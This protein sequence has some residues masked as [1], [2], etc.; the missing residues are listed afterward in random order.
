[1]K[2][3]VFRQQTVPR[4][5]F[6]DYFHSENFDAF[7]YDVVS[8]NYVT[9]LCVQKGATEN[10]VGEDVLEAQEG[11]FLVIPPLTRHRARTLIP[12]LGH[13]NSSAAFF[14]DDV[15]VLNDEQLQGFLKGCGGDERGMWAVLPLHF[16]MEGSYLS[17]KLDE[18][19]RGEKQKG[20][21]AGLH[22][23]GL[24][25]EICYLITEK[26]LRSRGTPPVPSQLMYCQKMC[27]YLELHYEKPLT[28]ETVFLVTGLNAEY[29]RRIFKKT[30]GQ[31]P[32]GYLLSVRMEEAKRLLANTADSVSEVARKVGYEDVNYFTRLFV[33]TEHKSP[34]QYRAML[35][36]E[37]VKYEETPS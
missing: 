8:L 37:W 33:R 11:D 25:M 31:S 10:T 6:A 19:I 2:Y 16:R 9:V 29:F 17:D 27:R 22:C 18:L 36:G 23:A 21:S 4:L 5:L 24:L 15:R 13:D 20:I 30:I 14:A 1:M 34:S 35:Y 12:G 3:L 28:E 32:K 7:E 26:S